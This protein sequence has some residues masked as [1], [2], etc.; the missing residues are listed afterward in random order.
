[1]THPFLIQANYNQQINERLF[2]ACGQLSP[3]QL[4]MD[5]GAF[6]GS[7]LAT[8]NHL[9][10]VDTYWFYQCCGDASKV[11]LFDRKNKQVKAAA[12]NQVLT[13]DFELL[14][15]W[16]EQIDARIVEFIKGLDES[17]LNR[18]ISHS[19]A[20]DHSVEYAL[21]KVLA[22]WF[23]HQTHHR[24]QVTA[25]LSQQGIDY[26]VTDLLKFDV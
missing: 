20:G 24:G 11:G 5:Q 26:G 7:I 13:D 10:V 12:L 25:L 14:S 19:L 6:F 22:H 17:A 2:Q 3:E 21:V 15:L 1:M 23:N 18:T 8:L 4:S 9:L 16:R